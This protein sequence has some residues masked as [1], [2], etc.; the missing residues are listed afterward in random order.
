MNSIFDDLVN[1][2]ELVPCL[3]QDSR[4]NIVCFG[5]VSPVY[6]FDKSDLDEDPNNV[7]I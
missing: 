2:P 7:Q 5:W 1:H 6:Y 4:G 3:E